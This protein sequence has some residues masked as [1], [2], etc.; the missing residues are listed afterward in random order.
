MSVTFRRA[1][2]P[3]PRFDS[4]SQ[5]EPNEGR[6]A[7]MIG[8]GALLGLC[9]TATVLLP[10]SDAPLPS[11]DTAEALSLLAPR[12]AE[13]A[14]LGGLGRALAVLE[15]DLSI[16][17]R[18]VAPEGQVDLGPL[19]ASLADGAG[20]GRQM[21]EA[22]PRAGLVEP[23]D[24]AAGLGLI[25]LALA[26]AGA[27][28]CAGIAALLLERLLFAPFRALRDVAD[29]MA[30]GNLDSAVPGTGR[31]D[32][33]GALARSLERL[34]IATLMAQEEVAPGAG[35]G[36]EAATRHIEQIA[37][38]AAARAL[39]TSLAPGAAWEELA[40]EA[41][42][43]ARQVVTIRAAAGQSVAAIARLEAEATSSV[44][45]THAAG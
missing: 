30:E 22:A 16:W 15:R 12:P 28:L 45:E 36:I 10:R 5:S 18:L 31:A 37:A 42:E 38:G 17:Q 33:A 4:P 7:W 25:L 24:D 43:L 39:E 32:E 40:R 6:L 20:P 27:T 9:L 29:A 3:G 44:R 41:R 23:A 2:Q 11:P 1:L 8:L 35:P 21:P 19:R 14:T 13:P 34:R 26:L